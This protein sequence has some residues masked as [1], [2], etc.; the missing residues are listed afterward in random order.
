[1]ISQLMG[2]GRR[3]EEHR[4]NLVCGKAH[5]SSHSIVH[6]LVLCD[7]TSLQ[8]RLRNIVSIWAA[9]FLAKI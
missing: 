1:M 5:F 2:K 3:Q 9:M 4:P 7:H 8:G 6:N